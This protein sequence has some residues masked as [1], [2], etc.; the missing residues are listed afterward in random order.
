MTSPCRDSRRNVPRKQNQTRTTPRPQQGS[1]RAPIPGFVS[2]LTAR[3]HP[4]YLPPLLQSIA[5]PSFPTRGLLSFAKRTSTQFCQSCV[6]QH[7]V[8]VRTAHRM[9]PTQM[10]ETRGSKA[11]TYG[12]QYTHGGACAVASF[13]FGLPDAATRGS[14][15]DNRNGCRKV[16]DKVPKHVGPLLVCGLGRELSEVGANFTAARDVKTSRFLCVS[17]ALAA[18]GALEHTGAYRKLQLKPA[19]PTLF[20]RFLKTMM[21][22]PAGTGSH[23]KR[24]R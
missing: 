24:R 6:V 20:P 4:P 9:W 8:V 18:R 21:S 17:G 13:H 12:A 3:L 7:A 16:R 10:A 15:I 19:A 1:S 11:A 2:G 23:R 22:G 14:G 5:P